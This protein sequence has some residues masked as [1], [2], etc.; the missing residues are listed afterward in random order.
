[1]ENRKELLSEILR[2]LQQ[3]Y[4]RMV[5]IERLTKELGDALSR[6]DQDSV[7]LLLK[8]RGDEMD[9]ASETRSEIQAILQALHGEDKKEIEALMAGDR[10]KEAGDFESEKIEK[11]SR[12]LRQTQERIVHIDKALSR[13]LAGTDSFY[14]SA[15]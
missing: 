11:I 10:Q 13:K 9:R 8:M 14:Q 2:R 12:Q 7:L 4:V 6:S 3:N 1:M 15:L 5:E